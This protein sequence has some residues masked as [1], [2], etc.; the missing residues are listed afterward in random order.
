MKRYLINI[1]IALDQLVTTLIGGYPDESLSSYAYRMNVQRK[2]WGRIWRPIID[3]LFSWQ[4]IPGGHCLA[5]Y[6][7]ERQRYQMPPDLR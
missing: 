6:Q 1:L 2:P 3:L 7:E 5:A 4:K